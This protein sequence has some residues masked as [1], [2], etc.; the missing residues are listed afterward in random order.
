MWSVQRVLPIALAAETSE[1]KSEYE[2]P[3]CVLLLRRFPSRRTLFDHDSTV[4][5]R[6][7]EP[8]EKLSPRH[9]RAL[10]CPQPRLSYTRRFNTA[11][12]IRPHHFDVKS[13]RRMPKTRELEGGESHSEEYVGERTNSLPRRRL[14]NSRMSPYGRIASARARSALLQSSRGSAAAR[15][16]VHRRIRSCST[17]RRSEN[18]R[19]V[20]SGSDRNLPRQLN[21]CGVAS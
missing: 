14:T 18:L 17:P 1:I 16:K 9:G 19:I 3:F 2:P 7:V 10:T 13:A 5:A 11:S 12:K 20:F 8:V 15:A 21:R 4:H 6:G